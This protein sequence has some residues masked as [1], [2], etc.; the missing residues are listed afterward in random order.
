[1]KFVDRL[2]I[3][4]TG[5]VI[6]HGHTGRQHGYPVVSKVE[7]DR[8]K[9]RRT[10]G[11]GFW[12]QECAKSGLTKQQAT[13]QA[14]MFIAQRVQLEPRVRSAQRRLAQL[15]RAKVDVVR[16]SKLI[17]R[18]S[19]SPELR[20]RVAEIRQ[21]RALLDPLQ[22][23]L[24]KIKDA[25]YYYNKIA[26]V[27]SDGTASSAAAS[28]STASVGAATVKRTAITW[29]W[30]KVEDRAQQMDIS[31]LRQGARTQTM[32]FAGCDYGLRTMSESV[33]QIYA[34][35]QVHVNRYQAL[36]GTL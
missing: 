15:L 14:Q 7:Q 21:S 6:A 25:I 35:I 22:D 9:R 30:N 16:E 12:R 32:A 31:Q 27:A 20:T 8:K 19:R 13:T 36:Q 2:E 34:D 28:S 18:Q 17:N 5:K 33:P 4:I 29:A 1:M 24:R 23:R 26:E 11:P 10:T 3:E